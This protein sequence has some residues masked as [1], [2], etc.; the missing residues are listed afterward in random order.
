LIEHYKK[1]KVQEEKRRFLSALGNFQQPEILDKTLKFAMSPDVRSQDLFI[2]VQ[3]TAGN[4]YGRQLI[5]PWIKANWKELKKRYAGG[6]TQL[7]TRIIDAL[8]VLADLQ[9]EKEIKQF[10]AKNPAAGTEMTV[11]QTLEVI[12]IHAKF[13]QRLQ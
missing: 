6:S 9:K 11:E 13:L 8:S 5:F 10:F 12:R 1:A 4:P 2:P 7:L 3:R